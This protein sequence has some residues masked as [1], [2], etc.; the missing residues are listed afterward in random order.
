MKEK[1]SNNA[2]KTTA[3]IIAGRVTPT[4]TNELKAKVISTTPIK[5]VEK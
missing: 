4:P 1:D 3:K 5:K 2:D